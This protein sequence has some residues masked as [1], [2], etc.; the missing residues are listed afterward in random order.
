MGDFPQGVSGA[1]R[2]NPLSASGVTPAGIDDYIV[3]RVG[4]F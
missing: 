3:A 4:I 1:G 2:S